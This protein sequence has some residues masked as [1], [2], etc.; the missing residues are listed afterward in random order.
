M[1]NNQT[2]AD[3]TLDL[4]K[5]LIQRE[6][7]T[8]ADGGCCELVAS[9]LRPLGFKAE[10]LNYH[11]VTNLWAVREGGMPGPTVVLA[12]HV[13]VVPQVPPK[14]GFTRRSQ[15]ASIPITCMGAELPI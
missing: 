2:L 1:Q 9:R 6:S 11:D 5:A 3:A 8:P 4:A 14:N 15:Q 13:D 12:G 10:L 7:V